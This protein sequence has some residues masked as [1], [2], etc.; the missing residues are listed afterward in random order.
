MKEKKSHR[1]AEEIRT[2]EIKITDERR[3]ILKRLKYNYLIEAVQRS[4]N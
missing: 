1:P 3:K 2:R 4:L